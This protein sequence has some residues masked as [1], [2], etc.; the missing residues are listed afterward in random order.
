MLL[1]LYI[2][3]DPIKSIRNRIVSQV[4]GAIL[5]R[6]VYQEKLY[7]FNILSKVFLWIHHGKWTDPNDSENMLAHDIRCFA[8]SLWGEPV[9]LQRTEEI[10]EL[11]CPG[12]PA[13]TEKH[14]YS[15]DGWGKVL[16]TAKKPHFN[17]HVS[18]YVQ[19]V[20]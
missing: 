6:A 11:D 1:E 3:L 16:L 17:R 13:R 12:K 5:H 10:W 20:P 2:K 4:L 15:Q 18:L 9:H 8:V 14:N 7:D 19:S